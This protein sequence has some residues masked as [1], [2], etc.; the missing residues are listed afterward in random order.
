[1]LPPIMIINNKEY[2]DI[3]V[4]REAEKTAAIVWPLPLKNNRIKNFF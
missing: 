4:R 1:M 3:T 2:A